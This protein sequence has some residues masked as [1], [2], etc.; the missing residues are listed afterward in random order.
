MLATVRCSKRLVLGAA[1]LV[2]AGPARAQVAP[3]L[4]A[5]WLDCLPRWLPTFGGEPGTDGP[6]RALAMF[7]DGGGP[8]LYVAGFFSDAGGVS[9]R[10]IAKRDGASWSPLGSGL[11]SSVEALVAFDDGTGP[12]LYVGGFFSSAGGAPASCI[13]KWDGASWAPVGAGL[14]GAVRA[15]A[16]FDDGGG[17]A[18]Y[19]GGSFADKIVK[20]D[21]SSWSALGGGFGATVGYVA[22]VYALRVFDD[23]EGAALHAGSDGYA[24]DSGDSLARC[25]CSDTE[26]PTLFCPALVGA[27]D[28]LGTAPGEIVTFTVT[29]TDDQD[30]SPD[31]VCVPPS[32]SLFPPGTTLVD[33]TATDASGNSSTAQFPV[34]VRSNVE[35]RKP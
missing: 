13:A 34:L 20:W 31:V 10:N 14:V 32:G 24:P 8:C 6:V 16:V 29:A 21:G 22:T 17:A 27:I 25:R 30:P 15:L 35:R 11:N 28:R 7:D 2:L 12:A 18:L 1:A 19:A 23:G 4:S 9:A 5:E 3:F 33:C 26:P